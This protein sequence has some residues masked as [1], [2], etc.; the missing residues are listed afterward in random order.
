MT[1]PLVTFFALFGWGML[2][3]RKVGERLWRSLLRIGGTG[4]PS[5]AL[6]AA[7]VQLAAMAGYAT[8]LAIGLALVDATGSRWPAVLVTGLA[9]LVHIPVA[10]G[11]LP[12]RR[13]PY[14]DARRILRAAG[15]T[16]AQARAATR[17]AGPF[18]FVG[19]GLIVGGLLAAFDA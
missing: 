14:A 18:A 19:M 16:P 3:R 12:D 7:G 5:A 1:M 6:L 9:G 13:E 4:S 2:L 11:A 10:A 15:A 8:A 17:T